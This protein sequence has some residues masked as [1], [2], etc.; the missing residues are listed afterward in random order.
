[1]NFHRFVLATPFSLHARHPFMPSASSIAIISAFCAITVASLRAAPAAGGEPGAVR[2]TVLD[3][4][5]GQPIQYAFLALIKEP[6][7]KIMQR[8]ATDAQGSFAFEGVP[9][10]DYIASYGLVGGDAST[11]P[12]FKVTAQTPAVDLGRLT[13]GSGENLRMEKVEVTARTDRFYN[14]IDRK[15]YDIGKDIQSSSGSASDL[16]Q[17]VPSVQLDIDGNLS[18]R[19][20]DNVLVL[21]DGKPSA[22]MS[23]INRADALAQLPAD[24]IERIEVITNPSAKYKPDG[25]AGIINIVLKRKHDA[26]YSGTFRANVGTDS[27]S[28]YGLSGNYNSGKFNISLNLS[29][30]RD[31]RPRFNQDNRTHLDMATDTFISTEQGTVETMRPLTR[32]AELGAEFNVDDD[33]RIG[34]TVD[35]NYRTFHRTSTIESVTLAA[36]GTD[37]SAYDRIRSDPEWQKTM[38]FGTTYRHTFPERGHELSAEIKRERHWEQ[39]DNQYSDVYLTPPMPTTYDSTLIKPT[40]TTTTMSVD[41]SQPMAGDA[42]LEA[43]YAGEVGKDDQNFL[44]GYLDPATGTW[45]VDPTETNRFIYRDS[46]QA[47][48]A[49]YGRPFGRFAFLAGLRLEEAF[50]DTNQVTTAVRD[51]SDYLRLYPTLHLSYDLTDTGQLVLNYSHRVHRPEGED[52]NPFPAYQD[53]FNLRAG[54]PLL[55]PEETH[56]IEGGYQYHKDETSILAAVYFRDTYN[57]FTTVSEYINSVTLLTTQENLSSN[58]SGGVE[59]IL[60]TPL[61]HNV[62]LN[63]STN[64][65]DNEVDASNLGYPGNRS[66]IG[67]DAKMSA[68]WRLSKSDEFQL[69]LN[70]SGRR[71]T[72]QGYRLPNY[73]ANIGYRH[74]FKERNLAFVATVSDLFDSLKERTVIDTPILHDYLMRRRSSRIIYAGFVYTFGGPVKSKKNESLQYDNQL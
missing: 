45:L 61:G 26:G 38:D 71:L 42:K 11:T 18:L 20:N 22:L 37:S 73:V 32:L 6:D 59:L 29:V 47:I 54:N 28:N 64:G 51:K 12:A 35:Y 5:T 74:E 16:L 17:N 14:S 15:V 24:S 21:I 52:L 62:T 56:S 58:R 57:A 36:D 8:T 55:R 2:G 66:S 50:I 49:T 70:Y 4:S 46:I 33:D 23:T 9:L 67:W 68:E 30:R 19:G 43:G 10:G 1:M 53:P 40:E 27:R 69:N 39:E 34:A 7:G 41:Y 44:G 3:G 65:Y 63:F 13:L 60:V 48:Y 72:A 25:T 31:F